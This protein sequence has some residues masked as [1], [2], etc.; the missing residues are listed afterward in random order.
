MIS[1]AAV[2]QTFECVNVDLQACG[3]RS[4]GEAHLFCLV[5]LAMCQ[6]D[7][8]LMDTITLK[9]YKEPMLSIVISSFGMHSV[10]CSTF[11]NVLTG[12]NC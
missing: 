5:F 1:N 3:E 7:D 6:L 4:H 8:F 9:E 12:L 10:V 11:C 2:V